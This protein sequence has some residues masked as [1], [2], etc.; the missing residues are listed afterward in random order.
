MGLVGIQC[1]VAQLA[2]GR[3]DGHAGGYASGLLQQMLAEIETSV[4]HV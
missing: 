2:C 1:R 4:I 3:P